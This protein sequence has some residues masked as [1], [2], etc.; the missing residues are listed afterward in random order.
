MSYETVI[1]FCLGFIVV[2]LGWIGWNVA[3]IAWHA[4]NPRREVKRGKL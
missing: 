4:R 3:I 2:Q 1:T